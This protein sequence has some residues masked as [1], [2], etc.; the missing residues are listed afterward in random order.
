MKQTKETNKLITKIKKELKGYLCLKYG[1]K[2][3]NC[4]HKCVHYS[5]IDKMF[6]YIYTDTHLA[7]KLGTKIT[8]KGDTFESY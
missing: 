7:L 3:K 1:C 6:K 4:D 2:R 8:I 5:D